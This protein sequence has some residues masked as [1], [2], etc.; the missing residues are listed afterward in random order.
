M[1]DMNLSHN[2]T[3]ERRSHLRAGTLL[4]AATLVLAACG[5]PGALSAEPAPHSASSDPRINQSAGHTERLR[6]EQP[7]PQ[8]SKSMAEILDDP[9]M[10]AVEAIVREGVDPSEFDRY[11]ERASRYVPDMDANVAGIGF[12]AD[13]LAAVVVASDYTYLVGVGMLRSAD[14]S[15]EGPECSGSGRR[16]E[17]STWS[18]RRRMRCTS[19]DRNHRPS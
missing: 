13:R 5:A 4:G 12:R 2:T 10:V 15:I 16:P 11:V 8:T 1:N 7:V 18:T 19:A 6:P 14:G 9:N 3:T 17:R